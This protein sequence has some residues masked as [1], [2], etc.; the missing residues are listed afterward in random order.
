[1]RPEEL[2]SAIITSLRTRRQPRVR[3]DALWG[4]LIFLPPLAE[5]RRIVAHLEAVQERVRALKKA[6][7]DTEDRLKEL[8][9][10]ILDNA[11]RGEL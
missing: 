8:E 3:L 11:F 5:Q 6:Q 2:R 7:D 4:T 9:R 1:M 10:P